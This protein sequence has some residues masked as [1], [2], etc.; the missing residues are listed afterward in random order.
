MTLPAALLFFCSPAFCA[1]QVR[2]ARIAVASVQA[3]EQCKVAGEVNRAK[4]YI[5]RFDSGF[6]PKANKSDSEMVLSAFSELLLI[7][8]KIGIHAWC[9]EYRSRKAQT[10][11]FMIPIR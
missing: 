6:D 5:K 4:L 11:N 9:I 10:G 2:F 8:N 3:Q 1:E 7:T